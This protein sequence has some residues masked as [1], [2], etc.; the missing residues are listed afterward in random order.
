MWNSSALTDAG[1]SVL[2]GAHESI[3][4]GLMNAFM[5]A[6]AHAGARVETFQIF[7]KN[8]S[9]WAQK[10]RDPG[11][12]AEFAT[13]ARRRGVVLM[14][15]DSYLINLAAQGE[16]YEKSRRAFLD[17]IERCAALGV[18]HVVFH[19]G[20]HVGAGVSV[21]LRRV[22]AALRWAIRRSA[23]ADV[24]LLIEL[25]AGQGTCLGWQF[26]ELRRLLDLVG[27]PARTGICF[28]TC[29][30]YAAGYDLRGDYGAV[31]DEFDRVVGLEHLHAF[32]LNDSLRELG[33]RVDRHAD[34]GAGHLGDAVFRKLVRDPRFAKIPGVLELPQS[35]LPRSLTRL[36]RWRG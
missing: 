16:L 14:A 31:W 4:G 17:E 27:E 9:T 34:I 15:H 30:A 32:H 11:E 3:A 28:D 35:W 10:P 7:T 36:R 24:R 23:G 20:A 21:G 6:D 8:G 29:H 18:R 33:T 12:I 22:A 2:L 19:P 5:H 25:T 1:L 13:E 26:A